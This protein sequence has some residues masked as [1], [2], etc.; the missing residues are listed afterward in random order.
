MHITSVERIEVERDLAAHCDRNN[1]I[2][3]RRSPSHPIPSAAARNSSLLPARILHPHFSSFSS[4][5]RVRLSRLL[6]DLTTLHYLWTY[7]LHWVAFLSR[8]AKVNWSHCL[9]FLCCSGQPQSKSGPSISLSFTN[10]F[11][12]VIEQC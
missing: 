2:K 3:L 9:V 12:T 10:R 6:V 4:F 1:A 5:Y 8:T 7:R 11:H